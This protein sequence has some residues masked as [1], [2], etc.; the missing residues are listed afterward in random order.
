M[1]DEI[2]LHALRFLDVLKRG[3]TVD[4]CAEHCDYV[5]TTEILDSVP[6]ASG[7]TASSRTTRRHW[8]STGEWCKRGTPAGTPGAP[9]RKVADCVDP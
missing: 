7:R 4:I 5:T 3:T 6:F 1:P 2:K 8:R 9:S